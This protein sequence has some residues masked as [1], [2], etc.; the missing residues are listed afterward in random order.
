MGHNADLHAVVGAPLELD[1]GC[2]FLGHAVLEQ[3][4]NVITVPAY[5]RFA[6]LDRPHQRNLTAQT[7]THTHTNTYKDKQR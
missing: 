2:W 4:R 7:H 3:V 6:T 5:P 1:R